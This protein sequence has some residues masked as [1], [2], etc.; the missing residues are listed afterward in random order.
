MGTE[1]W[2]SIPNYNGLYEVSNFGN[3]KSVERFVEHSYCGRQKIKER[4]LKKSLTNKGYHFVALS[5]N[6]IVKQFTVHK[7]VAITFLNHSTENRKYSI[8]HIDY[9][10]QNNNLTN[11]EVITQRENTS[12]NIKNKTSN[13]IGVCK[14]KSTNKWIA[15]IKINGK[16]KH[17]GYFENELDA[18]NAYLIEK[19]K[20]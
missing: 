9:N 20:L 17:L 6:G 11:I 18:H 8:N 14:R 4:F 13:Y 15:T 16:T 10:K 3:V 7:L 2:L 5:K 19:N 1:K 12:L